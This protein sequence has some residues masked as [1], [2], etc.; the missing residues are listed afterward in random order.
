[1]N[2][3]NVPFYTNVFVDAD[4]K[5]YAIGIHAHWKSADIHAK[6]HNLVSGDRCMCRLKVKRKPLKLRIVA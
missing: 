1:M 4:G 6:W 3:L 2:P 5:N